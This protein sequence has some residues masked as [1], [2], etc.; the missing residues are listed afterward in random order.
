MKYKTAP[1]VI[2][3]SVCGRFFLVTPKET[4]R[5]NETTAL[6]WK[7]LA[8]GA[9]EA[10]LDALAA[11]TYEID[12]PDTVRDDIRDLLDSLLAK[13]LLVRYGP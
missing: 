1:G 12:D 13:R 7:Q 5:I 4:F 3:T 11:G 8:R 9:S 2:L 6:Y 10:D